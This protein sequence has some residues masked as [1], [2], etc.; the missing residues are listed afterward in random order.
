MIQQTMKQRVVFNYSMSSYET[1]STGDRCGRR[2]ACCSAFAGFLCLEFCQ[3][4]LRGHK[5]LYLLI[6]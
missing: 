1:S 3:V 4:L 2:A 5:Q 6:A